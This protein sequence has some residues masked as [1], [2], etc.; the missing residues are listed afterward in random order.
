[1]SASFPLVSTDWLAE[2]LTAP[3]VRVADASWYMPDANRNP[4]AEYDAAHIPGAVFFDIE[5]LSDETNPLPHMMAPAAK[6]ASRMRRLGLGD[7]HMIVV[8]D[9]DGIFSSPRAW[10]M[11][12]AMGH[13][14]VAVLDGG[15]PKWR[16]ERRP[17]EDMPSVHSPRHFTPRVNHSIQRDF[18]QL[19]KL[20]QDGAQILDARSNS[21]FTGAELEPR[22]GLRSGHM[23]GAR[24][25]H[26]RGLLT[27]EGTLKPE[28]ELQQIFAG[29]DLQKPIATT[30]GSGISAAIVMLAAEILG[31]KDV[32]L[33]DGSWAEWGGRPEAEVAT[34]P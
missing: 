32:S 2:R 24:N 23:P 34:G 31:A 7:G 17:L 8:Y 14:D 27:A 28:G 6:F 26:Y 29:I 5:D 3:D 22:P 1:M 25:I 21:R 9:G 18:A 30:C 19:Q 15:L 13:K 16:R 20:V 4:R 33:Y 12:K 10:W 11:L